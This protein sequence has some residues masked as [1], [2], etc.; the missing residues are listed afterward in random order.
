MDSRSP[1]SIVAKHEIYP[2]VID[3]FWFTEDPLQARMRENI[4][5]FKGGT[6]T[7]SVFRFRPLPAAFYKM[8]AT[9]NITKVQTL[10]DVNFGMK[11]ARVSIP[12]FKEELQVYAKGENAVFSLLDE[13]ME[14]GL[15]S[16]SDLVGYSWWGEGQTDDSTI[17][18]FAELI[19]DGVIPSW[20]GYVAT[21]YGGSP[22]NGQYGNVLNANIFWAGNGDGSAGQINRPLFDEAYRAA[23][24]GAIRPNLIMSSPMGVS[25]IENKLEPQYRYMN[26][27]VDPFWGGD[28]IR[29][30]NAYIVE[31]RHIPSANGLSDA[32]NFG[33]GNFQTAAFA[34]PLTGTPR[35]HF[36]NSGDATNLTPG[37]IYVF[38]NTDFLVFRVSDDAEYGFG[39]SGFMG[40]PNTEKVVGSIKFAGNIQGVPRY[41]SMIYGVKG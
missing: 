26:E 11:F 9:H 24:Y 4:V 34:N 36:P 32:N 40:A 14:N 39:F 3:D 25:F 27:T 6:F 41:M 19:G 23:T 20:N 37:E 2:D 38:L 12:E 15:Q 29:Y 17:N 33:L 10:G 31:S 35:N 22:R 7:K 8:G 16:I 5:P 13:D 18:G 1:V 21:S 30:K 28:A